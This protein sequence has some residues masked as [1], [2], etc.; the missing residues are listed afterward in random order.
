LGNCL[1]VL[2]QKR[3][4]NLL[5]KRI[6]DKNFFELLLHY[7]KTFQINNQKEFSGYNKGIGIPQDNFLS[8]MLL[9]I[10]LHELD[11]Y[12]CI[13]R[14]ELIPRI[15]ESF[16][17][18]DFLS[19][20]I[21]FVRYL[22]H[23]L[24][25]VIGSKQLAKQCIFYVNKLLKSNLHLRIYAVKLVHGQSGKV[26][27]LN[28][29]IYMPSLQNIKRI[30]QLRS[31]IGFSRIRKRLRLKKISFLK[32]EQKILDKALLSVFNKKCQNII[33][34]GGSLIKKSVNSV[35]IKP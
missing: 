27:F 15:A 17:N 22:D 31:D 32:K 12:F 28:F 33:N 4:L 11:Q 23:F 26:R 9:N 13:L 14:K 1:E 35:F 18:K 2:N 19:M 21:R 30:K 34:L 5:K 3:L 10:Y 24:I 25:G 7:F 6:K 29:D 8:L 16:M 20:K